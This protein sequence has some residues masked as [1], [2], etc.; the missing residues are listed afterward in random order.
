V[1]A[2]TSSAVAGGR[3]EEQEEVQRVP[4]GRIADSWTSFDAVVVLQ[5]LGTVTRSSPA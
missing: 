2:G 5:Q 3:D 1:R 4:G